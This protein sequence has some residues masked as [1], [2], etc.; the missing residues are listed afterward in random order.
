MPSN[1]PCCSLRVD[2]TAMQT[3]LL[4]EVFDLPPGG[5]TRR[6]LQILFTAGV[7]HYR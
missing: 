1:V 2:A 4:N 3:R 7:S 6:C 5:V